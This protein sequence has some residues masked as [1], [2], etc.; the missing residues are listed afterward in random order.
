MIPLPS[1]E[2]VLYPRDRVLLMGTLGQVAVGRAF[3]SA[4]TGA[5]EAD[6]LYE[7]VRMDTVGVPQQSHAKG[8][9]LAEIPGASR[10]GV[11]IAGIHRRGVRILNPGA[12]EHLREGDELLVLGNAEQIR[13]FRGWLAE[14][15]A[16]Q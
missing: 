12:H 15:K 10:H 7:E 16:G 4:A 9:S 14:R 6:S 3:L 11:Q 1:S 13:E 2:S 5:V 8:L